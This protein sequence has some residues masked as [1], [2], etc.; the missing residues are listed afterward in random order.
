MFYCA[1]LRRLLCRKL[2]PIVLVTYVLTIFLLFL[3]VNFT[4]HPSKTEESFSLIFP[5]AALNSKRSPGSEF[6]N[7]SSYKHRNGI[8]NPGLE[9]RNSI[10][11][12][13][14]E[15]IYRHPGDKRANAI[16]QDPV[17]LLE[18]MHDKHIRNRPSGDFISF[19]HGAYVFS[20]YLDDRKEQTFVR[21][22]ALMSQNA[23][24]RFFYCHF[25]DNSKVIPVKTEVYQLCENHN[26]IFGGYFYSCADDRSNTKKDSSTEPTLSFA[27]CVSPLF[28]NISFHR[29]VEFIELSRLLGVEHFIFY[30]HSIPQQVSDALNYYI[31]RNLV[32]VIPWRLPKEADSSVWYYGQLL[33]NNDCLYRTMPYFDLV[34]FNDIDEFIVPHSNVSTWREAFSSMLTADRC[35][36]SFQSAFYDPGVREPS[37]S[38]LLTPV[39]T[40]KSEMYSKVRTKVMLCPWRV[41]EVGIH[42]ISKQNREDWRSWGV[43]PSLAYLHHYRKCVANF[44]MR[45]SVW[46]KDLIIADRYLQNLTANYQTVINHLLYNDQTA[47]NLTTRPR[48]KSHGEP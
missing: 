19:G 45:C 38:N 42:H 2:L 1:W 43:D 3:N 44:G 28:G 41:F 26:K 16:G 25:N 46:E 22:M 11:N 33:A 48:F 8:L 10:S 15:P 23:A 29:V 40:A 37:E 30:N 35:G 39:L 24:K 5:E 36:F 31:S 4:E 20:A 9:F 12:N 34:S 13:H 6:V 14:V 21:I 17:P 47:R 27:I 7:N 18:P 32:S